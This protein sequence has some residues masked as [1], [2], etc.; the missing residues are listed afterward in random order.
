M[1]SQLLFSKERRKGFTL[2]EI[3]T[4]VA[5]IG[6]FFVVVV[7]TFITLARS[8]T[9]IHAVGDLHVAAATALDRMVFEIRR[10]SRV[11]TANSVFNSSPGT[12]A[13]LVPLDGGGESQKLFSVNGGIEFFQD[14]NSNGLLTPGN[15]T[16]SNLIFRRVATSDAE[17]VRVEME[18][19]TAYGTTTKSAWFY[20][21]AVLRGDYQE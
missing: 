6:L 16:I 11:D 1:A 19:E 2:I 13:L 10:A 15:V 12:L 8:Y 3:L 4:Y 18:L 17:L 21:S 14:G 7:N 20:D 9:A 5:I